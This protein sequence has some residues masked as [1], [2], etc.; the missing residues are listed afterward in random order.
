MF[1]GRFW[2]LTPLDVYIYI[3]REREMYTLPET[4]S[5][6]LKIDGWKINFHFGKPGL[7]S[8]VFCLVSGSVIC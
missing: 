4:N 1:F 8:G 5:L 6:H 7:F 3:E 2:R